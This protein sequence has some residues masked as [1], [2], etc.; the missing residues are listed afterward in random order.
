MIEVPDK[1]REEAMEVAAAHHG[2]ARDEKDQRSDR[3]TARLLDMC[4]DLQTKVFDHMTDTG[5]I[6]RELKEGLTR[7]EKKV[8]E[9]VTAFP[10][11]DSIRHRMAHEAQIKAATNSDAF[12]GKLKFTFWALILT[13]S[14]G[15]LGIVIWKAVLVG[16]VN[17]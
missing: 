15:W 14:T 2:A 3:V 17:G 1:F 12:W 11:G 10:D 13:F 16:P 9:F 8:E 5:G 7:V 6:V 4:I